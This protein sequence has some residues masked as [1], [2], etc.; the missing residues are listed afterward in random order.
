MIRRPPRSTPFPDPAHLL[1]GWS[2]DTTAAT[3]PLALIM[4]RNRA[5]T[6]TFAINTYTLTVTTVGV[7]T[8]EKAPDQPTYDH[9]TAVQL[10]ATPGAGYH[11][12]GWSGDTTTTPN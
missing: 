8:V 12:V 6:A 9:G 1:S 3:S 10:T 7:G 4:T 5:L 11:F 2:G